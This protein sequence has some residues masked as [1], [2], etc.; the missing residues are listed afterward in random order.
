MIAFPVVILVFGALG[1]IVPEAAAPITP[2]V[3]T[4]LGVVMF[5]MGLTLRMPDLKLLIR[6]PHAVLI[7]VVSQFVIMPIAGWGIA[8]LLNMEPLLVVGMVLLGSVPGGA[9]SNIVAYL[10]R[11]NVALSVAATSVSTVLSPF[12]T[13]LLVLWLAGNRLEVDPQSMF[14]S[15]IRMVLVPVVVGAL[16]QLGARKFL[17]VIAPVV[18][19]VAV[20]VLALVIAGIMSGSAEVVL[21]SGLLVIVAVIA[22]N[23]FG[24]LL[25]YGVARLAGFKDRERRSI[26]VEVGM[27]NAGLAAAL[28]NSYYGP[29]ASLPA[30]IAT[31][32]HNLGGSIFATILSTMDR[33][34]GVADVA[35]HEPEPHRE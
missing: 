33:K 16:V 5:L 35:R 2:Y 15:I 27:Q 31:V 20:T 24:F 21:T 32:W 19:W 6:A 13:P 22:H 8:M 11:G 3:P 14:Q 28:A 26:A 29:L 4:L 7:A 17:P 25:G 23:T 12:L 9:S 34:R 10:A 1:T 18:P 30:A